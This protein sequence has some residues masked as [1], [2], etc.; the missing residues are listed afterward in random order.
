MWTFIY[1]ELLYVLIFDKDGSGILDFA[2]QEVII[3]GFYSI[4][5]I[6]FFRVFMK[7]ILGEE[8]QRVRVGIVYKEQRG[9][10][11]GY[12]YQWSSAKLSV[13]RFTRAQFELDVCV[14]GVRSKDVRQVIKLRRD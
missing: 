6:I 2:L 5:W 9:W 13:L 7:R 8:G 4:V 3:D 11:I 12:L 1:I 14:G 10:E